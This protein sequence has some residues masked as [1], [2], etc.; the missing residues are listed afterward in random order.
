MNSVFGLLLLAISG[1]FDLFGRFFDKL[2][3][4]SWHAALITFIA[5][6]MFLVKPL[7]KRI[8]SK[9]ESGKGGD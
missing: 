4:A 1:V 6:A 3:M 7:I 5:V 2:E 9:S 8:S